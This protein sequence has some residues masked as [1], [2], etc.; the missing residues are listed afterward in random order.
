MSLVCAAAWDREGRNS[1]FRVTVPTMSKPVNPRLRSRLERRVTVAD[2][3]EIAPI[4]F[5]MC[6]RAHRERASGAAPVRFVAGLLIHVIF[7]GSAPWA[8]DRFMAKADLL[9]GPRGGD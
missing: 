1:C 3:C 5:A 4:M 9:L 8:L 6:S 7:T 2:R